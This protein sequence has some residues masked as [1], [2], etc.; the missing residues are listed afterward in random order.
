ML[1]AFL[2]MSRKQKQCYLCMFGK[3]RFEE[4]IEDMV[5]FFMWM[6]DNGELE[7]DSGDG[8]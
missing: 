1:R 4:Y 2:P 3:V 6:T 7:F 8:V 5:L